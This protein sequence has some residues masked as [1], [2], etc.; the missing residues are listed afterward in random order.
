MYCVNSN[1]VKCLFT[2]SY[3]YLSY[4]NFICSHIFHNIY[5]LQMVRNSFVSYWNISRSIRKCWV[6]SW[7]NEQGT[8]VKNSSLCSAVGP[9]CV[10]WIQVG[11]SFEDTYSLNPDR[12]KRYSSSPPSSNLTIAS[13][14]IRQGE[15]WWLWSQK[16][17]AA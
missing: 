3:S 13:Y 8:S 5:F 12:D 10:W 7:S 11:R 6:S 2:S 17:I 1:R 15:H 16:K 4:H 9:P 14:G